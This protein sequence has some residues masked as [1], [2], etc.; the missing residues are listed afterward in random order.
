MSSL[1]ANYQVMTIGGPKKFLVKNHEKKFHI[2]MSLLT[3]EERLFY[4]FILSF[5]VAVSPV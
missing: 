2:F 3:I 1:I 5:F 4:T